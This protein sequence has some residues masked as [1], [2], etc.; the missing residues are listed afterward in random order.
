MARAQ[1]SSRESN[2]ESYREQ[3]REQRIPNDYERWR[4]ASDETPGQETFSESRRTAKT[5]LAEREG[6]EPPGLAAGRFQGGCICPLCHRSAGQVTDVCLPA[7]PV[8]FEVTFT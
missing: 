5:P 4:T 2:S 7:L 1:R 3:P 8:P 6:F